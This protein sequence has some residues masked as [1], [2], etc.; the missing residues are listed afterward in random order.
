METTKNVKIFSGKKHFAGYQS[1]SHDWTIKLLNQVW[2]KREIKRKCSKIDETLWWYKR[3]QEFP[4]SKF[5]WAKQKMYKI[6]EES[7]RDLHTR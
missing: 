4:H 6:V 7:R 5:F 1:V 3:K 2:K